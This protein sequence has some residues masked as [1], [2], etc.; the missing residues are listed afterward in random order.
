[1]IFVFLLNCLI[2][3]DQGCNPDLLYF[4]VINLNTVLRSVCLLFEGQL[5]TSFARTAPFHGSHNGLTTDGSY[6]FNSAIRD[7]KHV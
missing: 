3:K 2:R 4:G 5:G 6:H 1:M 7:S